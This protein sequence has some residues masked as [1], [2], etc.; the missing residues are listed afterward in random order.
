M[1]H[2]T[3]GAAATPSSSSTTTT[4][5]PSRSSR[6][7]ASAAA[8]RGASP[9]RRSPSSCPPCG[10]DRSALRFVERA[11]GR[12]AAL[13]RSLARQPLPLRQPARLGAVP[14]L[15]RPRA[16]RRVRH[17]ER[18]RRANPSRD[19]SRGC[20]SRT[21]SRA[22]ASW[23]DSRGV[24]LEHELPTPRRPPRRASH[25]HLAPAAGAD[26]RPARG[27]L[28][29]R[30][31]DAA[32]EPPGRA[33]YDGGPT[34]WRWSAAPGPRSRSSFDIE[35]AG[36]R[37]CYAVG[38]VL[39]TDGPS[40]AG[41]ALPTSTRAGAAHVEVA[42]E[43][44]GTYAGVV[45]LEP[46]PALV[47]DASRS[48]L[49]S[50]RGAPRPRPLRASPMAER[51]APLRLRPVVTSSLRRH[52]SRGSRV[53]VGRRTRAPRPPQRRGTTGKMQR[54]KPPNVDRP[55]PA[56]RQP[57]LRRRHRLHRQ[58]RGR[59]PR[60]VARLSTSPSASTTSSSTTTAAPTAAPRSS[61]ATRTT[62]S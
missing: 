21:A 28:G 33:R 24:E 1:P 47:S 8:P 59:L 17:R 56:P 39:Q 23:A 42:L 57:G 6:P 22:R 50:R 12:H 13:M 38:F 5:A 20:G 37:R 41:A 34:G 16:L 44:A 31:P 25:S 43:S 3:V 49:R 32:A 61:S 18:R 7:S 46:R 55:R 62:G 19:A 35:A 26:A 9:D 11:R 52:A 36:Q 58:G 51:C 54:E 53:A 30:P 40:D 10:E 14:A 60:G 4:R 45:E 29:R 48:A 27:Q 15:Q 2:E